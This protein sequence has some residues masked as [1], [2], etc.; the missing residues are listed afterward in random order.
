MISRHAEIEPERQQAFCGRVDAANDS[1][2][3]EIVLA[4]GD[5]LGLATDAVQIYNYNDETWRA[6]P[7][8]PRPLK[9][10]AT[11]PADAASTFV[12]VGGDANP[13]SSAIQ[14]VASILKWRPG[15]GGWEELDVTLNHARA[16]AS[17]FFVSEE[18]AGCSV[19]TTPMDT[20]TTTRDSTIPQE[21]T[22]QDSTTVTV[23]DGTTPPEPSTP[24]WTTVT[25]RT[26]TTTV[27]DSTVFPSA[28]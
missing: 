3:R 22:T 18:L 17:A 19:P 14:P 26:T 21:S 11:A 23:T 6:G 5:I 27:R 15:F 4:G 1:S 9:N 24:V 2:D 12:V 16:L 25:D 13:D 20:T 28:L 8:L 10:A 7:P